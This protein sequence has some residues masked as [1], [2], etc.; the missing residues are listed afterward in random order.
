MKKYFFLLML[1]TI[2][3]EAI[4]QSSED[5][6]NSTK[7]LISGAWHDENIE[8][9]KKYL[10]PQVELLYSS[11]EKGDFKQ[12]VNWVTWQ[13]EFIKNTT[14]FRDIKVIGNETYAFTFWTGEIEKD[15]KYPQRI[16]KSVTIPTVHRMKWEKGKVTQYEIYWDNDTVNKSL[17]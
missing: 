3:I 10:D 17:E 12:Y 8:T 11:G 14:V 7:D 9:V 5:L 16:G 1:A 6:I 4:A 13:N 15:D 2:S